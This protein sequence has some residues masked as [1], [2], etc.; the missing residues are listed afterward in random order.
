MSSGTNR[1]VSNIIDTNTLT[2]SL[3]IILTS[4]LL[5]F[6][7]SHSG[8]FSIGNYFQRKDIVLMLVEFVKFVVKILVLVKQRKVYH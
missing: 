7:L 4:H 8:R 6:L 5:L 3:S 1:G 2:P